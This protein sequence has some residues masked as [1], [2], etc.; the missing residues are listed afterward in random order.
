[1]PPCEISNRRSA[2]VD[3]KTI[4][5]RHGASAPL[6]ILRAVAYLAGRH[7]SSSDDAA[8]SNRQSVRALPECPNG[9]IHQLRIS[10]I[11]YLGPLHIH[12]RNYAPPFLRISLR[13]PRALIAFML[14]QP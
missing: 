2:G 3:R 9:L 8:F 10:A 5:G 1:L 13:A 14:A 7:I 12:H 11:A 4:G 6:P